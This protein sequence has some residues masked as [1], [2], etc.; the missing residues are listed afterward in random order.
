MDPWKV[1]YWIEKLDTCKSIPGVNPGGGGGGGWDG[2]YNIT[3]PHFSG[4]GMP[5]TNINM[6]YTV[7]NSEE[8]ARTN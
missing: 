7:Y 2:E 1:S 4:W 6:K 8:L 5:Y 3:S